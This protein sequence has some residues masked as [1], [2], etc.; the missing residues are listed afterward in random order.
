MARVPAQPPRSLRLQEGRSRSPSSLSHTAAGESHATEFS[1]RRGRRTQQP[2]RAPHA[3]S[4]GAHGATTGVGPCMSR[5]PLWLSIEPRFGF[6]Q[7]ALC[8]PAAGTQLRAK[9]SPTPALPG[10]LGLLLDGLVAWEGRPLFAVLDA[11]AEDVQRRPETARL[12]LRHARR[13]PALP[14]LQ[15]ALSTVLDH[16]NHQL[17]LQ[18]L[19]Q[20][21]H[22]QRCGFAI[23]DHLVHKGLLVRRRAFRR[24]SPPAARAPCAQPRT[25][26]V[27]RSA[28]L[29]VNR[30]ASG[31]GVPGR[32]L[33]SVRLT[34]AFR[35]LA[36]EAP[37]TPCPRSRCQRSRAR[38]RRRTSASESQRPDWFEPGATR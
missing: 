11:D 20:A 32:R 26:D 28:S 8:G 22:Q 25:E 30:G 5:S 33:A 16:R 19:G 14:G 21:L 18:G 23:A 38:R 37:S 31:L 4:P 29:G 10:A 7:L 27:L 3:G 9:L 24:S 2:T 1:A 13:R 36:Q 17:A 6:T 15:Q 12:H 35:F 34:G